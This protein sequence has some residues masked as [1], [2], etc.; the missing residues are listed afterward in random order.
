MQILKLFSR[1]PP[2]QLLK[3][4]I[5]SRDG[6]IEDGFARPFHTGYEI[7]CKNKIFRAYGENQ[8]F[9]FGNRIG[10]E[11]WEFSK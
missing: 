1:T 8:I 10:W 2:E 6:M 4:R 11:R 7:L 5:R 9:P 3:V